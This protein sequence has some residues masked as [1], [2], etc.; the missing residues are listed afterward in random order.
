VRE[1]LLTYSAAGRELGI[2]RKTVAEL[3]KVLGIPIRP[4]PHVGHGKAIT[5]SEVDQ[6]RKVLCPAR[7][8]A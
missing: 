7:A 3:V 5:A 6:L 2:G 4:H 8:T 1:T